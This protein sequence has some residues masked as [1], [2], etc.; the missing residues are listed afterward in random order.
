MVELRKPKTELGKIIYGK[1]TDYF[2]VITVLCFFIY[3]PCKFTRM[4][5]FLAKSSKAVADPGEN[6]T[7]SL[8]SR[9][10]RGGRGGRGGCGGCGGRD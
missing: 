3:G 1:S 4:E 8:H 5:S 10:G 7:G 2:T 6:L 9:F